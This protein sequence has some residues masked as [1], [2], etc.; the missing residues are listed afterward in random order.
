M[1]PCITSGGVISPTLLLDRYPHSFTFLLEWFP[2]H[3]IWW[4]DL[5][6]IISGGVISATLLWDRYLL[7][8]TFLLDV[9][10]PKTQMYLMLS[11]ILLC[12]FCMLLVSIDLSCFFKHRLCTNILLAIVFISLVHNVE[13]K[14]FYFLDELYLFS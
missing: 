12:Y 10:S 5:P 9:I 3:Y 7:H 13:I 2:L 4:S 6:Y 14:L 11:I 1:S 8:F